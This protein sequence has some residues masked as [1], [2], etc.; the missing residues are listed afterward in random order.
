M[1]VLVVG[2]GLSGIGAAC[3]L[4]QQA[5]GSLPNP[6]FAIGCTNAPWTLKVDLVS[7]HVARLVAHM[8]EH[9]YVAVTPRLPPD[10]MATSPFID[11]TSG[12]FQRSRTTLP[13]QGDRAPWRL[14][15]HFGNDAALFRGPVAAQDLQFT[16]ADARRTA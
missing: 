2:A 3:H 4:R 13:L 12:C 6:A 1:D 11:M 9:G 5:S 8:E 14:R 15:Q 7:E 16:P 10:P